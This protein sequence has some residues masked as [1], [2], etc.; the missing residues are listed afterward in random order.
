MSGVKLAVLVAVLAAVVATI[1]TSAFFVGAGYGPRERSDA[2][3]ASAPRSTIAG[4]GLDVQ[5]ILER[6]EAS[7]VAIHTGQTTSRG[8]FGG[9]GT[10]IVLS[11]DG[12]I[13]TNAHVVGSMGDIKVTLSNGVEYDA[14]LVGSIP[15]D[16]IAL[17]R[18][19]GVTNLKPAELGSSEDLRVGDEVLAIGNALNL[20]GKPTV[21]LGIVSAKD[22]TIQAPN[23]TLEKLIQ[24]DAAINP[25]NSGG[26]L[27]NSAGQVVGVNT[28]II[29]DAQNIGF[30]IP[31]DLVKPLIE[32]IRNGKAP[33]TLD[34]A[35]LG[36][37]STSVE[38]VT[39]AVLDAFGVRA[40]RGAFIQDVT[41]GSA[42]FESGLREGDVITRV[43]G[44]DIE[45]SSD[46]VTVVRSKKPGD[47]ITI[48]YERR[49]RVST[50]EVT[51]KSR[52]D[53][54][55]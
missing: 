53:S 25:G 8:V 31:I 33:V 21:T 9:A 14:E 1:V 32:D 26:P 41:P 5:G 23:I 10:G 55:G 18:A 17:I 6:T 48:E 24:T 22:R 46:V 27:I 39:D 16:D 51:L 30:A 49:G 28:A 37:S 54:G 52:R 3:A 4:S 44:R 11:A 40:K 45:S 38:D 2:S 35:F 12:L 19:R 15:D 43:D 50:V 29:S 42:A 20:G 34:S 7:V 36:V 13:L 47:K